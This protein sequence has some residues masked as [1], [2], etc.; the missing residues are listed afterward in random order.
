VV[1]YDV[2]LSHNQRDIPTVIAFAEA[3]QTE[4]MVIWLDQWEGISASDSTAELERVLS[5]VQGVGVLVGKDGAGP[6]DEKRLEE[7]LAQCVADGK[8]VI[9]I[10]LPD[11]HVQPELPD[12]L[13]DQSWLDFRQGVTVEGIQRFIWRV[14]ENVSND[15]SRE[16]RV[17]TANLH[18][19]ENLLFGRHMEMGQLDAAWGDSTALVSVEAP[20]GAGKS[21]LVNHWLRWMAGDGYRGADRVFGWTFSQSSISCV[22]SFF[23]TILRWFGECEGG[24]AAPGRSKRLAT[25]MNDH[26]TLLVLDEPEPVATSS[27]STECHL[28]DPELFDLFCELR[29]GHPGLCL[30][31]SSTPALLVASESD[32]AVLRLK[33]EPLSPDAGVILLAQTGIVGSDEQMQRAVEDLDGHSMSLLL[34]GKYLSMACQGDITGRGE[35]PLKTAADGAGYVTTLLSGFERHLGEGPLMQVLRL[36]SLLDSP[37]DLGSVTA[38]CADPPVPGLTNRLTELDPDAWASALKWLRECGLLVIA[39]EWESDTVHTHRLIRDHFR[40]R[41][42]KQ[43][44]EGCAQIRDRLS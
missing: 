40:D 25:Q 23:E 21:A 14:A 7:C 32:P 44:P 35:L 37:V 34:L 38:I 12:C 4:G 22:A 27:P 30:V 9:P 19:S 24:V 5:A 2:L 18:P 41:L 6:W 39:D 16:I 36:V 13:N 33:L 11:A 10:L 31:T 1:Q 43:F 15:A 8:P 20:Y 26:R 28:V 17:S 3:L 29:H 42:Q